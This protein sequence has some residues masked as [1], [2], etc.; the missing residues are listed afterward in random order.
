MFNFNKMSN[1]ELTAEFCDKLC[2]QF[3]DIT[4]TDTACGHMF[5]QDCDWDLGVAIDRFFASQK[6]APF[7]SN[8]N[9]SVVKSA[10]LKVN[11]DTEMFE[12]FKLLSWNIDGLDDKNRASRTKV[13]CDTILSV[14]PAVVFLQEV[15]QSTLDIIAKKLFTSYDIISLSSQTEYFTCI[16]LNLKVAKKLSQRVEPFTTSQMGRDL[17]QVEAEVKHG[18]FVFMTSHLESTKPFRQE[19]MRQFETCMKSIC[20]TDRSKT[21]LFGGDLNMRDDEVIGKPDDVHDLWQ[22]ASSPEAAKFT[23]DCLLNDNTNLAS[24]RGAARF[25]PRCRFDRLY[26]R[27]SNLTVVNLKQFQLIGKERI[28]SCLCFPSDHFGI[29]CEFEMNR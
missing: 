6:Q 1:H 24:G 12:S 2:H 3:A 27:Q 8:Y 25:K 13:V 15:V 22:V 26:L 19:R 20:D 9:V 5:L 16:L 10:S 18:K 21:V 11:D 23:W 4:G 17:L 14:N 7:K 29:L 28:R